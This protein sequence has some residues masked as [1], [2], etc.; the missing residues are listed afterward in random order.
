MNP[1]RPTRIDARPVSPRHLEAFT[2]VE[3]LVVIS[4]IA[5]LASLI[6]GVGGVASRKSKEIRVQA[7]LN[8]LV[9][10][11]ENYKSK[12]GAYPPS[13]EGFLAPN[14]SGG[15]RPPHPSQLYYE[16][17]GTIYTNRPGQSG[18]FYPAGAANVSDAVRFTPNQIVSIFGVDGF[19]NSAR[20]R[21][22][23]KLRAEF[24]PDQ[25]K[26]VRFF[27][28]DITVLVAPIQPPP[29]PPA[30]NAPTTV[31]VLPSGRAYVWYYDS[32]S[33]NRYNADGFDLWTEVQIG[34]KFIRF[35]NWEPGPVV[36]GP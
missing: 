6:L 21:R 26:R 20:E 8:R 3:L 15:Q 35:S 32:L 7:E 11:I 31:P 28:R 1:K 29:G 22:N 36:T 2:L 12:I 30:P 34:K 5:L 16:L 10:L 27:N 17:S 4:V 19:A 14:R 13:N 24:K 18:Y 33:S 25:L 9:T 23:V